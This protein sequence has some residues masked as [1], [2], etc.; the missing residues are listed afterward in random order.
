MKRKLDLEFSGHL[1]DTQEKMLADVLRRAISEVAA[2]SSLEKVYLDGNLNWLSSKAK[3]PSPKQPE[4]PCHHEK[5]IIIRTPRS[6][7]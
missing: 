2:F 4:Y 5:H 6:K 1:T 3:K 7:R